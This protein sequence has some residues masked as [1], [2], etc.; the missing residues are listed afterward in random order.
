M[1]SEGA[2][3]SSVP[4]HKVDGDKYKAQVCFCCSR[5]I[6]VLIVVDSRRQHAMGAIR[7][8]ICNQSICPNAPKKAGPEAILQ[9]EECDP[10]RENPH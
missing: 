6:I 8:D 4:V 9:E 1:A 7:K 2:S 5:R 10:L 3:G